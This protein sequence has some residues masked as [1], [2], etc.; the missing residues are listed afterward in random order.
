MTTVLHLVASSRG[1]GATH[2]R[3]LTLGLGRMGLCVR[4]AMPEDAGNVGREDLPAG[5]PFYPV[6]IAAGFSPRVLGQIRDL[7]READ[8]LH[9]HGARGALFGRLAAASLGRRR[10][11]IVYTIHGFAAPHYPTP[12]REVLLAIERVLAPVTDRW[13]CV[14]DAERAALLGSGV[15]DERRAQVIRNGIDVDRFAAATEERQHMRAMLDIP[16]DAHVTTTVCRLYRPR[17]FDTL[18][19]SF[20]SVSAALPHALLL[21][22]GDGPLRTEIENQVRRLGLQEQVRVLGRRR[23]VPRLLGVT[24]VFVLSSKGWEGLPRTVLEAMAAALPVVASDVGGTGEAVENGLTGFLYRPGDVAALAQHIRTLAGDPTLARE[25]G[26]RGLSRA[27]QLFT[28]ARMVQETASLYEE[29][30]A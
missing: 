16:P 8:I 9:V 5:I 27:R 14:S 21:V 15:A 23:D 10:P 13:V 19:Q 1:G 28:A 4:V 20:R 3:D 7:A 6:D 17:D 25:M 24:D 30:L 12:K 26:Q 22:V 29:V 2:V 11:R 18:L